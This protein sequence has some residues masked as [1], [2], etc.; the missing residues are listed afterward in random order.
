MAPAD[1][2]G[3]WDETARAVP[4][5]GP[6]RQGVREGRG[7]LQRPRRGRL[8]ACRSSSPSTAASPEAD[9]HGARHARR[10]RDEQV[11]RRPL[12]GH[13]DLHAHGGA[14]GDRRPR[15]V[16]VP[17][18][19]GPHRR[20][21]SATRPRSPGPAARPAAP[22]SCSSACWQGGPA[23]I[24]PRRSTSPTRRRRGR[25]DRDPPAPSTPA[26]PAPRSSPT[27]WRRARCASSPCRARSR[28]TSAA[29]R[30]RRSRAGLRRRPD[31]LARHRG[32]CPASPTRT[33]RTSTDFVEKVRPP[34]WKANL[35]RFGWTEMVSPAA[36]SRRSSP[37]SS[38]RV[39]QLVATSDWRRDHDAGPLLARAPHRGA[40]GPRAGRARGDGRHPERPRRLG[41]PRAAVRAARDLGQRH[42]ARG[43][44]VL[45]RRASGR[46]S[47]A[48]AEEAAKT[49]WPSGDGHGAAH[50]L[51]AGADAVRIRAGDGG[52]LPPLLARAG[53][54]PARARRDRGRGGRRRHLVRVHALARRAPSVGP[55]GV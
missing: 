20:T 33:A 29:R 50:R 31:Q 2:G 25:L 21:S 10:R 44:A 9:G 23:S 40:P 19:R 27:R 55:W 5:G 15:E 54:R 38:S 3:G 34:R 12:A 17:D 53:Q 18:A 8:W 42:R 36:S 11:R 37:T 51:P 43:R 45:H 52:L 30:R 48:H 26:C 16:Q 41:G 28:S 39:K 35:E 14:G 4:A 22:T 47:R 1:P 24:P 49:H 13:A 7:G 6:A 46:R 32:A